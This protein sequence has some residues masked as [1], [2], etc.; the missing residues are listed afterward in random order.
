VGESPTL[1][2]RSMTQTSHHGDTEQPPGHT[3]TTEKEFLRALAGRSGGDESD[4]EDD[5]EEYRD[6][7]PIDRLQEDGG[8]MHMVLV[9]GWGWGWLVELCEFE[10]GVHCAAGVVDQ[11]FWRVLV[12]W[13]WWNHLCA[14]PTF[15]ADFFKGCD[16]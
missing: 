9:V 13:H 7:R 10:D 4:A 6:D 14:D 11:H 12:E 8:Y 15:V 5:R 1:L 2:S 3:S 16:D